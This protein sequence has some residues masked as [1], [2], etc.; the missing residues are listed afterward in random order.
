MTAVQGPQKTLFEKNP[1]ISI[2]GTLNKT[3]T[4][5]SQLNATTS[6]ANNNC[7]KMD[8][9]NAEDFFLH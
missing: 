2:G 5:I 6:D 1:E 4:V 7:L 8:S 3:S 9:Q